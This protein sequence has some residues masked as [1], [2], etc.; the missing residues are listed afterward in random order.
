MNTKSI[1]NLER[2]VKNDQSSVTNHL[3]SIKFD[4]E[5]VNQISSFFPNYKLLANLR[6]GLWYSKYYFDTCYFKSTDGHTGYE[7]FNTKRLNL[8][9]AKL[10]SKSVGLIIVDSTR[11]GKTFPDSMKSTV[12]KSES[13]DT[14]NL[15]FYST[16][17]IP[18]WIAVINSILFDKGENFSEYF[19]IIPN[20]MSTNQYSNICENIQRFMNSPEFSEFRLMIQNELSQQL[21]KPMKIFW[22]NTTIDRSINWPSEDIEELIFLPDTEPNHELPYIPIILFSCSSV[23]N[24]QDMI[25]WREEHSWM[26]I[27]GAGDDE[28]NWSNGLTPSVFWRYNDEVLSS[29]EPAQIVNHMNQILSENIYNNIDTRNNYLSEWN[30]INIMNIKNTD[31]Y[32]TD[33]TPNNRLVVF[34]KDLQNLLRWGRRQI[35]HRCKFPSNY[36]EKLIND[37][38]MVIVNILHPS[39]LKRQHSTDDMRISSSENHN[40]TSQYPFLYDK[41]ENLISIFLSSEKK[42]RSQLHDNWNNSRS[43]ETVPKIWKLLKETLVNSKEGGNLE[44]CHNSTSNRIVMK[45][46]LLISQ[47][48]GISTLIVASLLLHF[49]HYTFPSSLNQEISSVTNSFMTNVIKESGMKTDLKNHAKISKLEISY[50]LSHIQQSSSKLSCSRGV[51]KEIARSFV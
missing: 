9:V 13:Y 39:L 14:T 11:R 26:Y 16:I 36:Y 42:Y 33:F 23:F 31:M 22:A 3:L 20:S 30:P 17:Q 29:S 44:S 4:S 51:L 12:F 49:Y 32:V 43:N 8:H 37:D 50:A 34:E 47:D 10:A 35:L 38:D 6:N 1:S 15:T 46:F 27:Q 25:L 41:D 48:W 5:S 18:I 2:K 19:K 21:K 40:N 45:R 7:V 28:E 24:E